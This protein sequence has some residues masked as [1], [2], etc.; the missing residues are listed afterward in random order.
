METFPTGWMWRVKYVQ[1]GE[2]KCQKKLRKG[3]CTGTSWLRRIEEIFW[4]LGPVLPVVLMVMVQV[5]ERE[6]GEGALVNI[7]RITRSPNRPNQPPIQSVL[8]H[9]KSTF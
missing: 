7:A 6:S 9:P 4:G 5:P 1:V 8:S 3:G 2:H